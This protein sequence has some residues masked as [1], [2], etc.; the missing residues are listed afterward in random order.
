[1]V[2]VIDLTTTQIEA[3]KK[4]HPNVTKY[5]RFIPNREIEKQEEMREVI[6]VRHVMANRKHKLRKKQ[7][8][9][10]RGYKRRRL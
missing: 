3:L 1:M 10:S 2:T 6:R 5:A 7:G 8:I 4:E 9:V